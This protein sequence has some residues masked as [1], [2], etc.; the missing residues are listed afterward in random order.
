MD[1]AH[2]PKEKPIR[3]VTE[4]VMQTIRDPYRVIATLTKIPAN[5]TSSTYISS[6]KNLTS[7]RIS[8]SIH[9]L[10]CVTA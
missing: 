1:V 2:E 3:P 8:K 6:N 7:S 9:C 5:H 10:L 4:P